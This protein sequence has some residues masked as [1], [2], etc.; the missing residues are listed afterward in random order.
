MLQQT[1]LYV[2]LIILSLGK[3]TWFAQDID[4]YFNRLILQGG[5]LAMAITY[6]V[7]IEI[8]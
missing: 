1:V 2:F 3:V 5:V 4:K 6:K 7:R 8:R